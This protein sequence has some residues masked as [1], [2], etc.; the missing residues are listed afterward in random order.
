MKPIY[1]N[2]HP[3]TYGPK[4]DAH[5]NFQQS[6]LNSNRVVMF[7]LYC[8]FLTAKQNGQPQNSN[9]R[10]DLLLQD[11]GGKRVI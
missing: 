10:L 5:Q 4:L 9:C 1:V 2:I 3:Y 11:E 8:V 7:L 6:V